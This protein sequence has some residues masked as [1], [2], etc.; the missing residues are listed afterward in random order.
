MESVLYSIWR[1]DVRNLVRN[2]LTISRDYHIQPSEIDKMVYFEYEYILEDINEERKEQEKRNQEEEKKY[3]N[4][5]SGMNQN[6]MMRNISRN[7]PITQNHNMGININKPSLYN[8][9]RINVNFTNNQNSDN[10]PT[11]PSSIN[12]SINNNACF[13]IN[14]KNE[15]KPMNSDDFVD[16]N[17]SLM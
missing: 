12:N 9:S 10:L 16:K 11:Q 2:K 3:G 14:S 5:T 7:M 1:V 6:S 13:N 15:Y 8:S 17:C 4:L